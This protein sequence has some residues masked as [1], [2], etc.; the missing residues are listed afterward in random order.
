MKEG[1]AA[2]HRESK[3]DRGWLIGGSQ[4]ALEAGGWVRKTTGL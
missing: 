1:G 4:T 2:R 3:A